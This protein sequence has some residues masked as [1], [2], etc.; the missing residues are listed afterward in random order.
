[1]KFSPEER[2]RAVRQMR[3]RS[4]QYPSPSATAKSIAPTSRCVPR[5][6]MNS[7]KHSEAECSESDGVCA[8]E[9]ARVKALESEVKKLR[10][11]IEKLKFGVYIVQALFYFGFMS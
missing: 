5:T 3:K 4:S 6:L 9:C 1:M 7:V 8:V 10:R 11:E 2:K